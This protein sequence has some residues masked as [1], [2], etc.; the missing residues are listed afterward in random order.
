MALMLGSVLGNSRAR[1]NAAAAAQLAWRPLDAGTVYFSD[2]GFYLESNGVPLPF[3]WMG[4]VS[5]DA[6]GEGVVQFGANMDSGTFERFRFFSPFAELLL[7]S[8]ALSQHQGHPYLVS[9]LSRFR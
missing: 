4:I 2:H 7:L 9:Y 8:W 3:S 1:K 5:C 6:I